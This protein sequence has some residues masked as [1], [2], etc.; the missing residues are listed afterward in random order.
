[1]IKTT[2]N[3]DHAANISVFVSFMGTLQINKTIQKCHQSKQQ[4]E[5]DR[6]NCVL[7]SSNQVFVNNMIVV[8]YAAPNQ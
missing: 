7:T 2:I 8:K 3:Y 1:M 6:L 5:I 4:V